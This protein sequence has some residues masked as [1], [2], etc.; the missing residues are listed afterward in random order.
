MKFNI[1]RLIVITGAILVMAATAGCQQ[2]Q[3]II[4]TPTPTPQSL[5]IGVWQRTTARATSAFSIAMPDQV[6][7]LPDGSWVV[8]GSGILNGKYAILDARR[9]K[10]EGFS[11]IF[12]PNFTITTGGALSFE[13]NGTI[14]AYIR[15]P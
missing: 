5:I 15:H 7:F 4:A 11:L 12:T 14:V 1:R 3:N 9:I 6:E 13:D 8:P 2:I 10:L